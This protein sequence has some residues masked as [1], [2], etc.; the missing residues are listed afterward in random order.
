[1][2]AWAFY[3]YK[4]IKLAK[5][6]TKKRKI[7]IVINVDIKGCYYIGLSIFVDGVNVVTQVSLSARIP[8]SIITT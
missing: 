8:L 1:M 4:Y 5:L 6:I 3:N 7:M 2:T